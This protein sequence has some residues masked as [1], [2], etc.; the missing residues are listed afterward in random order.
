M[1]PYVPPWELSCARA[2]RHV[3]GREPGDDEPDGAAHERRVHALVKRAADEHAHQLDG[4]LD[5]RERE[6][7]VRGDDADDELVRRGVR[8]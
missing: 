6:P 4:L 3:R 2:D 5:G 1:Y 7:G 8:Q